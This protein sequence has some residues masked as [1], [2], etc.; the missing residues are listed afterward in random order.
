V[1]IVTASGEQTISDLYLTT[2]PAALQ[3]NI[4]V[5][6]ARLLGES[7]LAVLERDGP[8]LVGTPRLSDH[9]AYLTNQRT[10]RLQA[11]MLP[12]RGATRDDLG[13]WF[14]SQE[15]VPNAVL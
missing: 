3:E 11:K 14:A 12:L 5:G 8:C 9:H 4:Q 13:E 7:I 1:S 6:I 15:E 10:Y 2:A